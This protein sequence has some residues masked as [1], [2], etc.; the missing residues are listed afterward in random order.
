M[1]AWDIKW[2]KMQL[3]TNLHSVTDEGS[4]LGASCAHVSFPKTALV[5]IKSAARLHGI[6]ARIGDVQTNMKS[7]AIF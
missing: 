4:I 2:Y 1:N 3:F 5:P 6:W 7:N